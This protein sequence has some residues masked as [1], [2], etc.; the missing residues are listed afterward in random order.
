LPKHRRSQLLQ[1]DASSPIVLGAILGPI[2]E[3]S[4]MRSISGTLMGLSILSLAY[5]ILRRH[6]AR[7]RAFVSTR[8]R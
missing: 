5:R 8:R 6:Y 1:Y 2:A 4:F 7:I 3:D